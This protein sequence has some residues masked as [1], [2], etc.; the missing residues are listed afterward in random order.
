MRVP[1]RLYADFSTETAGQKVLAR[2]VQS[3][4]KQR[5]TTRLTLPSK[6]ELKKREK[7]G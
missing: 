2:N 4:K 5:H 6:V 3:D 7:P 1:I